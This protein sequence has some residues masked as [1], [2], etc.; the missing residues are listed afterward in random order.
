LKPY[1][2]MRDQLWARLT[3]PLLYDLIEHG[4]NA[5]HAETFYFG[6]WSGGMFFP[7]CPAQD[8]EALA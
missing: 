6:V 8:I 5:M 4:E 3:R 1:V 7:I 2:L